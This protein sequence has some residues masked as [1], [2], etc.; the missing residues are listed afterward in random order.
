MD[1]LPKMNKEIIL[2]NFFNHFDFGGENRLPQKAYMAIRQA[3]RQLHLAPGQTV[4]EQEMAEVLG[5]SRTPVREALVRLQIEGW[6]RIIPRRGFTVTDIEAND[7]QQI[8]EIVEALDGVAGQLAAVRAT[9]EELQALDLL[10]QKQEKAL[11]E[12]NLLAW[13]EL[14]DQF[15]SRI[16]DMAHNSRLSTVMESQADQLY[17]ARLYTIPFRPHPT[18]SITDHKAIVSVL[19][20]GEAEAAKVILESHRFRTRKEVV[21]ALSDYPTAPPH[22]TDK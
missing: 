8:Y 22:H 6:V 10:I 19:K 16:V 13:T 5:M 18:R 20:A 3:V 11:E 9:D 4:L 17:R 7:L 21:Q 15:H 2:Y 14:D 12:N 1:V